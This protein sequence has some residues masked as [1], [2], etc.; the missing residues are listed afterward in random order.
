[1]ANYMENRKHLIEVGKSIL[2]MGNAMGEEGALPEK[3]SKDLKDLD[4]VVTYLQCGLHVPDHL[5][6]AL[7]RLMRT[8]G[9]EKAEIEPVQIFKEYDGETKESIL[10]VLDGLTADAAF[11]EPLRPIVGSIRAKV[12]A[13]DSGS[14]SLEGKEVVIFG[15]I[16]MAISKWA[17]E[18]GN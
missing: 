2:K 18:Q 10:F 8:A 5:E 6:P 12:A 3:V 7:A 16:S 9:A 17:E 13:W 15:H 11:P 1:M 4:M 14:F